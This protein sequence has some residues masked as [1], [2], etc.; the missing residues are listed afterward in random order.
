MLRHIKGLLGLSIVFVLVSFFG[1]HT[2]LAQTGTSSLH[3]TVMDKSGATV[4][5][6]AVHLINAAQGL[7]WEGE[8]GSA[9]EYE[10]LSVPPGIYTLTVEKAGFRKY[11]QNKIQLQVSTPGTANV[12]L[13]IGSDIQTVE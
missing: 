4:A 12:M 10:F 9:G 1:T 11:E 3:G 5:G 8:T 7:D 13:E 2:S 6:A